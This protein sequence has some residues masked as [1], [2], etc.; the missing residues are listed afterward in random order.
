MGATGHRF[1]PSLRICP[2]SGQDAYMDDH[3]ENH[4]R[5]GAGLDEAEVRRFQAIL[6][7]ERGVELGLPEAW[8]R[9]IEVLMLV[10]ML[11]DGMA[12]AP[13]PL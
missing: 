1:S 5:F 3:P 9:A 12:R 7:E 11:F 4:G 6:R 8:S 13:S 10:E 2:L